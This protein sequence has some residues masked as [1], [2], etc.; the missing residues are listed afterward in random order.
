MKYD[1]GKLIEKY[2]AL[3]LDY[4]TQ[5]RSNLKLGKTAQ[6]EVAREAAGVSNKIVADL[7]HLKGLLK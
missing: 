3:A 6:A 5:Y 7:E 1:I 4:N 2:T